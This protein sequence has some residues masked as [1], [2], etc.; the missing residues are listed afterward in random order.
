MVP[1]RPILLYA[2]S[3]SAFMARHRR[4]LL[5]LLTLAI[6]GGLL[7]GASL[8]V[9]LFPTVVFPR[10]EVSIDAGDRPIDQTEAT[11]T[12][13]MEQAIR[14]APDVTNLRSTTSRGAADINVNFAWNTNMDLA[15]Q[16]TEASLSRA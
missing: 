3:F 12:R 6:L 16:R 14:A 2:M 4:S 10:I 11:I 13:P 8:P 7:A 15:L 5:A 9:G 1:S